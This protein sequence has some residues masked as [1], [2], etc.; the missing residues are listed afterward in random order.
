MEFSALYQELIHSR[1]MIR[2]L[3][4]GISQEQARVRPE[5]DSWSMLEV[6]C[7][8]YDEER[9]DFRQHLDT[10]LNDPEGAWPPF[11][12]QGWVTQRKY[13][14]QNFEEM[15]EKLFA[16]RQ[17]SL[18]WLQGLTNA[19]WNAVSVRDWGTMSAGDMF[20]S[21]VAHDNL[22]IRQLVELRRAYIERMTAPY[23]IGYGGD[24]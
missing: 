19:D 7:H 2:A 5:A 8:L 17:K 10:I 1:E 16:E 9:E 21:W 15:R 3:T 14:E 13:N 24:W 18:D 20:T 6:V 4:D 12:P 23:N 22:H 11:D